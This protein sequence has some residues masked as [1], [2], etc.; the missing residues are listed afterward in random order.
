VLL[1]LIVAVTIAHGFTVLTLRRSILTE[2]VSRRGFHLSREY[3]TDPLEIMFAREVARAAIVALP[4]DATTKEVSAALAGPQGEPASVTRPRL[5]RHDQRLFPL[6]DGSRRLVGVVTR[7][8]LRE[9]LNRSTN[10]P[11]AGLADVAQTKPVI[12]YGDEPLR[13]LAFRMA[14][15]GVTRLPVVA[16]RDGTLIGM[17]GL[18]DLLTARAKILDA[19]QRREHLLG[20]ALRLR[21]FGRSRS[22]A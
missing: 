7:R 1:P 21:V 8:D 6:V 9:W 10:Q 11:G 19:E 18:S 4:V 22:A 2:K 12:A 17:I 15:T 3:A 20:S 5:T 14:E 16:R 13:L